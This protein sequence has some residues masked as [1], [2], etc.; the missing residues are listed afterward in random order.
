[1]ENQDLQAAINEVHAAAA[2]EAEVI[3]SGLVDGGVPRE[4]MRRFIEIIVQLRRLIPDEAV[5]MWLIECSDR[6]GP[7]FEDRKSD[8]AKSLSKFISRRMPEI[9]QPIFVG[10]AASL[11]LDA[12]FE[13]ERDRF[14]VTQHFDKLVSELEKLIAEDMIL[15]RT[16]QD[17]I[18]QL[19]AV[20]AR[21]RHGSMASILL[22]M[23]YGQFVLNAFEGILSAN[24]YTKPIIESFRAEFEKTKSA[25]GHATEATN[26]AV[27]RRLVNERRLELFLESHP[28]ARDA[29]AGHLSCPS[30]ESSQPPLD[31]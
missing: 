22:T 14:E 29:V 3:V 8:E 17:A 26:Q 4:N 16:V 11:T 2:N 19:K 23:N 15:D 7:Q 6:F 20:L 24:K 30:Y 5:P 10:E 27:I 18:Q 28:Q 1:M 13:A 31:A 25:V 9:M 12:M 21:N